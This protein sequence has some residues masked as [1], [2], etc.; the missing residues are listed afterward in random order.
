MCTNMLYLIEIFMLVFIK[1][2][3]VSK[4]LCYSKHK[5]A[6]LTP[7]DKAVLAGRQASISKP[8]VGLIIFSLTYY[9]V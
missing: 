9:D 3:T 4:E 6:L 7:L 2:L 8:R 5:E 1:S